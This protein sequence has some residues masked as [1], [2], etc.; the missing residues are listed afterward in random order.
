MKNIF[1]T[2]NI[3]EWIIW[4]VGIAA[5]ISSFFIFGNTRYT[6]LVGSLLGVS[7]LVFVSKGNPLGQ[8]LTV[9]FAV[10]YGIIS[11][12]FK[13]YGE[14]ITYLG[15]SAPIAIWA[16]VSWL[17]NPYDGNRSEVRVNTLSRRE[18]IL[19]AIGSVAVTVAFYFILGALGTTNL[20][21]ST[22]S[23][24]TSFTAAYLTARRS[25][26]YA[27]AYGLN[28]VV[29]IV[30]WALACSVDFSYMPMVV[31]FC[32]FFVLDLYGF[33]NWTRMKKK[34]SAPSSNVDE[35]DDK[36]IGSDNM[37]K[38]LFEDED[39]CFVRGDR[40]FRFRVGAIIIEDGHILLAR[41]ENIDH[42]YSVGGGVHMGETTEQAV[43]REVR[44]ET[45]IDYEID[46]LAFIHE[47]F[48][49]AKK[50]ALSH[51]TAHELALYY[52]MKPR[53]VREEIPS[54]TKTL[55]G[56]EHLDW[57]PVSELSR[58]NMFPHFFREY[59]NDLPQTV[60]HVVTDDL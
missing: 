21:V 50:G 52:I 19:F 10:F 8:L 11:Y 42:Y 3:A 40:R 37:E 2:L 30:M 12:S 18:W 29:L 49:K 34:Q 32:L 1:K 58:V 27:V 15:M 26:F 55:D 53:G 36:I 47:N 22:L 23:V 35:R 56:A 20:P 59:I 16:L 33:I 5:V 14:M 46:R 39:C 41:S 45:G 24:F 17:R 28:D 57:V 38:K 7:A 51:V 43:V 13:Y 9:V 54:R 44:E 6:Y 25:R 60:V 4:A 31:C 48:F